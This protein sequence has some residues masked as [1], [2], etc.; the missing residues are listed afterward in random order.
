MEKITRL[1]HQVSWDLAQGVE[2]PKMATDA[3]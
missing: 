1:V 3:R 2:R